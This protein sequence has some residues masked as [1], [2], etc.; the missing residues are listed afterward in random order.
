MKNGRM[1][2][3]EIMAQ[4]C[5]AGVLDHQA[6]LR[7][8]RFG[9]VAKISPFPSLR[10]ASS[11]AV[12]DDRSPARRRPTPGVGCALL[13]RTTS[14]GAR[15]A[16]IAASGEHVPAHSGCWLPPE[17]M[18]KEVPRTR[19]RVAAVRFAATVVLCWAHTIELRR[20]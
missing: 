8:D 4:G 3:F 1:G 7:V 18:R 9:S 16:G 13:V 6:K 15:G 10:G 5:G 17:A 19:H 11:A 14:A 20:M 12:T 2:V